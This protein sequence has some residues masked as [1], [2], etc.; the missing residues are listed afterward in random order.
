MRYKRLHSIR[1]IGLLRKRMHSL[2]PECNPCLFVKEYDDILIYNDIIN[3][4]GFSYQSD[5]AKKHNVSKQKI[6]KSMR[7][8]KCAILDLI[9]SYYCENEIPQESALYVPYFLQIL[10]CNNNADS[11]A[12]IFVD[13]Y[14]L[15]QSIL[16]KNK[17]RP[18]SRNETKIFNYMQ[19]W[20]STEGFSRQYMFFKNNGLSMQYRGGIKNEQSN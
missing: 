13:E 19:N 16:E 3:A 9:I 1:E 18:V 14:H 12:E 5:Y 4:R 10:L 8:G 17:S 7:S 11:L 15:F 2:L 6:S 20:L